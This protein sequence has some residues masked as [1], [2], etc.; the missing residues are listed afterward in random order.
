MVYF[1]S[2][3]KVAVIAGKHGGVGRFLHMQLQLSGFLFLFSFFSKQHLTPRRHR[4]MH[5]ILLAQE[6]GMIFPFCPKAYCEFSPP[7]KFG[8]DGQKV[9]LVRCGEVSDSSLAP[10]DC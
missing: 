7:P 6:P 4:C 2:L 5:L 3:R 1:G 10:G 9:G 8:M